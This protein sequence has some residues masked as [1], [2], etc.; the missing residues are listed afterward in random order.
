MGYLPEVELNNK[1]VTQKEKQTKKGSIRVAIGSKK[2]RDGGPKK[3]DKGRKEGLKKDKSP[4]WVKLTKVIILS[5]VKAI[6]ACDFEVSSPIT[7][8]F[9]I[10]LGRVITK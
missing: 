5:R 9:T 4:K 6:P 8:D 2:K 10:Y 1:N 3:R 7:R